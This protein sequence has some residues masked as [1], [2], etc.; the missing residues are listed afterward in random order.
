MHS[1][2]L[3]AL[4]G[5]ALAVAGRASAADTIKIG[6]TAEMTGPNAES[7]AYQVNGAKLALDEINKAG[8]VLG[9]QLELQVEDTQSNNN[10]AVNAL[11]RLGAA[12][13][14]TAIVGPVRS[15]QIQAMAPTLTRMGVP[16][17]IGGTD[18]G[19]TKTG[20]PWLFRARPNDGYSAKVI[21]DFGV[22]T[23]GK[24]KWAIVHATDAFGTGGKNALVE[25]LKALG[26]QPVL[27]QGFTSNTQDFTP[28]ILAIKQ[29]GADIIGTYIPNSPDVGIFSKQLR[30]L[31]V[32]VPWV[33]SPSV[34]T[35]TAMKLGQEALFGTFA[36]AD[37]TPGANAEA[38][39]YAAK[40]KERFNVDPDFYSSWAYDAVHLIANAVKATN[41]TKPEDL[42]K[43]FLSTK[44]WKGVEGTYQF[45]KNGDGLHGYNIVKNDAGKITFVKNIS[46]APAP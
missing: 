10:G 33:G 39:T 8:G 26:A 11:S 37:F 35:A 20:N 7:G 6:L 40:Y 21:A 38:Q 36:I 41:S 9:K 17:L 43:A 29:A 15:T 18:P 44:G 31:G 28:V 5:I 27:V 23:L 16:M 32:N 13:D 45:D 12:G 46:F 4:V 34:A 19:L 14:I 1:R 24:K 22:N 42:K 2:W 25:A 3:A 30:Q